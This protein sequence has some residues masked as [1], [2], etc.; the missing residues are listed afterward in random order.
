MSKPDSKH[1]PGNPRPNEMD[2]R[3][4]QMWRALVAMVHAP[5][6]TSQERQF[7]KGELK[8]VT[9]AE[10]QRS[11]L[12][13]DMYEPQ[14]LNAILPEIEDVNDLEALMGLSVRLFHS[15]GVITPEEQAI[16]NRLEV[17][18]D[19]HLEAEN[20]TREMQQ[21]YEIK[22]ADPGEDHTARV[23]AAARRLL[24]MESNFAP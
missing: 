12:E 23:Q 13:L 15:D 6:L 24:R 22:P 2:P 3:Y 1:K 19:K 11:R 14:D 5:E 9:M 7:L 18:M 16:M 20:L 8:D 10:W 17:M 21:K 4:F